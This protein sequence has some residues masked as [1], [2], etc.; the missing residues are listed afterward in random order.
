MNGQK[1]P[2]LSSSGRTTTVFL[3]V[4]GAILIFIGGGAAIVGCIQG[5]NNID[6]AGSTLTFGLVLF[7]PG[8]FVFLAARFRE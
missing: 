2:S 3:K 6:G 1:A 4:V 7:V 8:L 5:A